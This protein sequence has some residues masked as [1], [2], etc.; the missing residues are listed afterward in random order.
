MKSSSSLIRWIARYLLAAI[1]LQAVGPALAA[2][3]S[4]A[5]GEV[6]RWTEICTVLGTKW[7]KQS[8]DHDEKSSASKHLSDG[9][10]LF[11]ASTEAVNAFDVTRFLAEAS[12]STTIAETTTQ[13]DHRFSGHSILSRAPPR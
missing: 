12:S 7:V 13:T 4:N 6:N 2:A 10:C 8:V 3:K 1:L 9:H 11:C 5:D